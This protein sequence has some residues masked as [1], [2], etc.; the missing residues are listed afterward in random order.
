MLGY[1]FFIHGEECPAQTNPKTKPQALSC[2]WVWNIMISHAGTLKMEENESICCCWEVVRELLA[3]MR[4]FSCRIWLVPRMDFVIWTCQCP[5]FV[6]RHPQTAGG[7][8]RFAQAPQGS[9][10]CSRSSSKEKDILPLWGRLCCQWRVR[11]YAAQYLFDLVLESKYLSFC[12]LYHPSPAK[13]PSL[14]KW[15]LV[16]DIHL[17][18]PDQLLLG[19]AVRARWGPYKVLSCRTHF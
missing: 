19:S 13:S 17:I 12:L 4:R 8:Y 1:S 9:D 3:T 16:A 15:L 11:E 6:S 10:K 5:A 7:Q 14:R 18:H 2:L